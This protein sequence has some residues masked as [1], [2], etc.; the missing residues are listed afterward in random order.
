[1]PETP[2]PR[3]RPLSDPWGEDAEHP[4]AD[5]RDE[6]ANDDTRLGY[7]EWVAQ[8]REDEPTLPPTSLGH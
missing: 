2:L 6:V 1:M 3:A 5:W 7:R 4:V 8:R